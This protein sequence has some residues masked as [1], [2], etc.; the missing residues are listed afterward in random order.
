MD[1]IALGD[2]ASV[3]RAHGVGKKL[4]E[5]VIR[6]AQARGLAASVAP[7]PSASG[8]LVATGSGWVVGGSKAGV[9]A[10]AG[11]GWRR[12]KKLIFRGIEFSMFFTFKFS[13]GPNLLQI[14]DLMSF[15]LQVN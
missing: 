9:T 11:G 1:A 7:P 12:H 5:L 13:G 2:A 10:E 15:F 8:G 6:Q 4:A 3:Q 14:T